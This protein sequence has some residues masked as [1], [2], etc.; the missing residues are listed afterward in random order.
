M[1]DGK[2]YEFFSRSDESTR[3]FKKIFTTILLIVMI[4]GYCILIITNILIVFSVKDIRIEPDNFELTTPTNETIV[5]EGVF[6]IDNDHWNS[7]DIRNLKIEFGIYSDNNTYLIGDTYK[8]PVIP[9][10]KTSE[11][12][13]NFEFNFSETPYMF[14]ILNET[15][16]LKM[17]LS[18]E[19][20]YVFYRIY[21]EIKYTIDPFE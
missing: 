11:I 13:I 6:I 2:W 14:T 12:T 19:F 8:K 10:L 1:S 20:H 7:F 16:Y 21:F 18:I 4:I 5:L 9:R 15:K 3:R 17:E